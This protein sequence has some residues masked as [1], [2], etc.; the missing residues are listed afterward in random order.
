MVIYPT[1][2]ALSGVLLSITAQTVVLNVAR[3]VAVILALLALRAILGEVVRRLSVRGVVCVFVNTGS[4]EEAF[5]IGQA[6]VEERLTAAVNITHPIRSIYHWQG[7]IEERPEA[8]LI[9]KTTQAR[10]KTLTSRV[11]ELHSYQVPSIIAFSVFQSHKPYLDWIVET[12]DSKAWWKFIRR[13]G[14]TSSGAC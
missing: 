14:R 4:E 5:K 13:P 9:L 12:T 6:L 8:L 3:G 11:K 7:K 2:S 10:L 1:L